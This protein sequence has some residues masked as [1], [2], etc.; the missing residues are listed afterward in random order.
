MGYPALGWRVGARPLYGGWG[1]PSLVLAVEACCL[2]WLVMAARV[3]AG[4]GPS[5]WAYIVQRVVDPGLALGSGAISSAMSSGGVL[6][7]DSCLVYD[8]LSGG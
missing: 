4:L 5:F 6:L 8:W 7:D 2:A 3:V 1:N